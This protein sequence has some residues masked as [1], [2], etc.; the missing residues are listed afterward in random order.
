MMVCFFLILKV[1][2]K[3]SQ[4]DATTVNAVRLVAVARGKSAMFVT[5]GS[6]RR[7]KSMEP[8]GSHIPWRQRWGDEM[9]GIPKTVTR[10]CGTCPF[11]G[12]SRV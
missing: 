3:A 6:D 12:L 1:E 7:C 2:G 11:S 8:V 5:A 10:S 4:D 9:K